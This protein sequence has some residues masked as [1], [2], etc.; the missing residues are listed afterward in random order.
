MAPAEPRPLRISELRRPFSQ[1]PA[2][3]RLVTGLE[4]GPS[5]RLL[6]VAGGLDGWAIP[7]ARAVGC[8][9]VIAEPDE[10]V[11]E[12]LRERV[13]ASGVG[14]RVELRRVELARL[15]F[16]EGEFKV[17]I[18][19]ASALLPA[20]AAV[21]RLARVV[22]FDGR[23]ALLAA[24]RVGRFPNAQVLSFWAARLGEAPVLPRELLA[25]FAAADF[26]PESAESLGDMELDLLYRAV[27]KDLGADARS[28]ELKAE[29]ALH[30]GQGGK[31]GF[32][33]SVLLG[34][35]RSPG[36]Q[37]AAPRSGA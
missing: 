9:V 16:G 22:D 6:E 27:E 5:T 35:R 10:A 25:T 37:P 28:A 29:I 13:R 26:E 15:P 7:L 33:F 31:S 11:L 21:G 23:L 34:R 24:T 2:V 18:A 19:H 36:E 17:A 8:P 12:A 14:Q 32:S 1:E 20:S 3:R 30:R 4:L